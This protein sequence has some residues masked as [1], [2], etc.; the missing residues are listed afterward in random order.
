MLENLKITAPEHAWVADITYF[1][2]KDGT[3]YISLITDAF[4]RKIV[5]YDVSDNLKTESSVRELVK[6][7]YNNEKVMVY[8]AIILIAGS[9][10]VLINIK[11]FIKNAMCNA[12]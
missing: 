4:L 8:Y 11:R 9:N 6:W 2:T 1:P 7:Q 5:G 10:I 12:Q 3:S